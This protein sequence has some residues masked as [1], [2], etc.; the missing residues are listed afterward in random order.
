MGLVEPAPEKTASRLWALAS[1]VPLLGFLVCFVFDLGAPPTPD[2]NCGSP[3]ALMNAYVRDAMP[4]HAVA[5][6]ICAVPLVLAARTRWSRTVAVNGVGVGA[7]VLAFL[8]VAFT[9]LGPVDLLAAP[10]MVLIWLTTF[11][12]LRYGEVVVG[13]MLVVFAL[14][15]VATALT[16][17][18]RGTL[19][20][21]QDRALVAG[22]IGV[23]AVLLHATEV[24]GRVW[25]F[26]V[27]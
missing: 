7:V 26:C 11:G 19:P 22:A 16:D 8:L 24:Y 21:A 9:R 25:D 12:H 5:V 18:W 10:G 6:L 27:D 20:D 23:Y 14:L 1:A 4:F 17:R 2:L 13:A 3:A 15:G